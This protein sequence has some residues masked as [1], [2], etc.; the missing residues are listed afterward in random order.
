VQPLCGLQ[1]SLVHGLLSLHTALS[2]VWTQPDA[3]LQVSTVHGMPSSQEGGGPPTHVGP[4]H[5]SPVVHGLPSLHAPESWIVVVCEPVL[6]DGSR[7]DAALA[8]DAEAVMSPLPAHWT[9][10]TVIVKTAGA[11]GSSRVVVHAIA[12]V[13]PGAG[14]PHVHPPGGAIETKVVLGGVDIENEAESASPG[15][16]STT[17]AV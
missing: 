7:S 8:T 4:L 11:A 15:P 2:P 6:L 3:E 17:V 1:K 10:F 12:P 13:P 14:A 9:T 5:A 16:L